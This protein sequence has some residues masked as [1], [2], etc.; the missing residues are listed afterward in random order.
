MHGVICT[1]NSTWNLLLDH[2]PCFTK[3]ELFVNF[4][5]SGLLKVKDVTLN[6]TA[7]VYTHS[8]V[9]NVI[10]RT[11]SLAD[12]ASRVV[13]GPL[14]LVSID[15]SI[16]TSLSFSFWNICSAGVFTCWNLDHLD[17]CSLF[18]LLIYTVS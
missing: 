2:I 14:D 18:C 9:K 16:L 1:C 10:E 7:A 6:A 8:S 15:I 5:L 13:N 12:D 17:G 11:E 4:L 3:I